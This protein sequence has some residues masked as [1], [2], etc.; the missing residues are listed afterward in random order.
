MSVYKATSLQDLLSTKLIEESS[1]KINNIEIYHTETSGLSGSKI[2]KIEVKL[3]DSKKYFY[4]KV[5]NLKED[6]IARISNDKGREL[7]IFRDD[8]YPKT[9]EFIKDIYLGY[10]EGKD[11]YAILMKDVSKY[12][13]SNNN[14]DKYF[15]YLDNL[16]KFHSKFRECD[17]SFCKQLLSVEEY[18]DF[19]TLSKVGQVEELKEE[20]D[21]GW[22][23]I[24]NILG[25]E[26]YEKYNKLSENK[27][28]RNSYSHYPKTF[29]HGDFRP[30]N[31]VYFDDENIRFI[32][33]ANSGCG[34][35]TLDL[36]WYIISSV[37]VKVDKTELI[38]FYKDRLSK[39]MGYE[40]TNKTWNTLL[41]IG[42][43]CAC[44][45]YLARLMSISSDNKYDILN[46]DWWIENLEFILKHD[47]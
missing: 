45:M 44:R 37:D 28:M 47:K 17:I 6:W 46:I 36:F 27:K 23:K 43:L 5:N 34:P 7:I 15:Q 31:T 8:I 26:L 41:E 30:D 2:Y 14:S 3:D 12:I 22:R 18:Y 20:N 1:S 33:F 21:L 32:D 40:Y 35:C 10:Y 13:G 11:S 39:Y 42:F 4:L 38:Y 25:K 16:A 9:E 24:S 29:I 19:L